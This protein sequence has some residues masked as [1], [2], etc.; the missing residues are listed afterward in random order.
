MLSIS[1]VLYRNDPEM[2]NK[3]LECIKNCGVEYSLSIVDNSE[4]QNLRSLL[5]C[6]PKEYM[7]SPTGNCGFGSA[8]NLAYEHLNLCKHKY[9][10]V[11]NPD[12][13][14]QPSALADMIKYLESNADIGLLSPKIL[15]HSGEIQYLC[16]RYPSVGHLFFRRFLPKFLLKYFRNYL[17]Y[18]EM[19]ETGY[20]KVMDVTYLS[21]CFMLFRREY[22][23]DIGYF[24][25]NFFMYLEDADISLRMSRK[26]RSVFYP[27]AFVYHGWARGS[28]NSLKLT[29]VTIQSAF[30]FFN[31]HGWKWF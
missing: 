9:H 2:V 8:H 6:E 13:E 10:L 22:L 27:D 14:F 26:Y 25:D 1:L 20:D 12:I 5:N 7:S 23:D 4:N 29:W 15:Y 19:R 21:G 11:I 16:K 31:K 24:D 18:Y 17:D 3:T 28:H 30:Y